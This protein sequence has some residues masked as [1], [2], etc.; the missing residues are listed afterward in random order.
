MRSPDGVDVPVDFTFE[1]IVPQ[2][3]LVYRSSYPYTATLTFEA[4]GESETR[5]TLRF[6]FGT[7]AEKDAAISGG[8][9]AGTAEA[10][11]KLERFVVQ[12]T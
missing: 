7:A 3:R 9:A 2:E 12:Q 1:E 5:L 8:F 11:G 6:A 4:T 10:L